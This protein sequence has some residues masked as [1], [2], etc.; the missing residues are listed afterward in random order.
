M[1]LLEALLLCY[2]DNQKG[3]T[4]THALPLGSDSVPTELPSKVLKEIEKLIDTQTTEEF[5]T[6]GFETYTT[7]NLYFEIPS[8]WARGKRE[9]LCLSV[10]T[11]KGK[12]EVFKETLIEGAQR[13]KAIPCI[14]KAFHVEHKNQDQGVGEKGQEL[15]KFLRKLCK[16]I[17]LARKKAIIQESKSERKRNQS[18][19]RERDRDRDVTRDSDRDVTRDSDRDVTRDSDRDEKRDRQQNKI[20]KETLKDAK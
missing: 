11:H 7:A 18:R 10:L 9:I 5:F 12:P 16:D 8:E 6:Y 3:P 4:I 17:I 13:L 20:R 1:T 19:D 2:F 15:D 14:Y